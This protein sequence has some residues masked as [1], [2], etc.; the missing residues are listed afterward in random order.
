MRTIFRF[1]VLLLLVV[2]WGLAAFSLHVVRTPDDIPITL[3]PKERFGLTDTYV[4]TRMWTLD[5]VAQHSELVEKLISAGKADVLRHVVG[6]KPD[7]D[8]KTQL[9]SA[10]QHGPK[11][12]AGGTSTQ[13]SAASLLGRLFGML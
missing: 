9:I 1:I 11:K 5:D 3:V 13:P 2:G 8:V 7:G 4:D 6:A 10:I 12:E